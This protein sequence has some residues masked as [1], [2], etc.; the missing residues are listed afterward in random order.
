M[1]PTRLV[2]NCHLTRNGTGIFASDGSRV[3]LNTLEENGASAQANLGAITIYGSNSLVENNHVVVRAGAGILIQPGFTN[4][5][6]QA[7]F[8]N[9]VIVKNVV[10]GGGQ[11]NYV[12]PPGNDL[13]PTGAAALATSPWANIS[14]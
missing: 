7:Q 12:A 8:T 6:S 1:M 14:H 3:L 2:R 4:A 11:N 5:M 9:N 13:G 10:I